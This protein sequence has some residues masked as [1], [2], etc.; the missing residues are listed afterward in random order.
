MVKNDKIIALNTEITVMQGNSD[1]DYISIARNEAN[2]PLL[3]VKK[4]C[5]TLWF[6]K[7]LLTKNTPFKKCH[8][9][10]K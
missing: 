4:L 2:Y 6:K 1:S 7:N 3:C 5:V 8:L 9:L 10:S